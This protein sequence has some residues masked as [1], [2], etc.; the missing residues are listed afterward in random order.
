MGQETGAF[1]MSAAVFFYDESD[2]LVGTVSVGGPRINFA[3][4]KLTRP[5]SHAYEVR[6]LS[7]KIEF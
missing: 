5:A 3:G 4:Q 1:I 7:P 6:T 2:N